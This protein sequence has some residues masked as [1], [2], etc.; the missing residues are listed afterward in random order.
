MLSGN[1]SYTGGTVLD[2]GILVVD[3][4]QALGLG[5]V[6]VNGGVLRTD[7]Q[8]INV[9]GNYRQNAGGTLRLSLGGNAPG[10]PDFLNVGG[11]AALDGTLQLVFLNSFQ[12]KIGD[13]IN[14]VVAA[15][16][17]SGQFSPS[18]TH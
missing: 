10:Q 3:S 16:G 5:D 6:V 8:P 18:S 12:P 11:H 2:A 9:K 1:N 13:K 7:P 4:A 15:G 14:L 17:V